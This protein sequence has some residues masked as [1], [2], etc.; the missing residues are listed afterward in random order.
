VSHQEG[1]VSNLEAEIG[2][3]KREIES[4]SSRLQVAEGNERDMAQEYAA[5]KS[6]FLT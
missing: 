1:A 3:L 5:L 2:Q 4:A 6:N